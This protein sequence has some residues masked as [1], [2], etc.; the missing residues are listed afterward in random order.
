[1][2]STIHPII[3][4]FRGEQRLFPIE[5]T[6]ARFCYKHPSIISHGRSAT[7]WS[8]QD[9]SVTNFATGAAAAVTTTGATTTNIKANAATTKPTTGQQQQNLQQMQQQLNL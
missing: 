3:D 1:V 4:R 7:I 6:S 2:F 9:S 5:P 8:T